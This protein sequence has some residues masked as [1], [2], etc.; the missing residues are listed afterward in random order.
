M[1]SSPTPAQRPSHDLPPSQGPLGVQLP[2]TEL[3]PQREMVQV[4][5]VRKSSWGSAAVTLERGLVGRRGCSSEFCA[6]RGLPGALHSRSNGAL[7]IINSVVHKKATRDIEE[8][9][10]L[11]GENARERGGGLLRRH[12]GIHDAWKGCIPSRH[13]THELTHKFQTAIEQHNPP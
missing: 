10:V 3:C 12:N 2:P 9:V 1:A 11:W 7:P 8:A 6:T 4:I 13:S 5:R